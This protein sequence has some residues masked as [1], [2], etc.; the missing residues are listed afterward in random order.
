MSSL[1]TGQ[2]GHHVVKH[3]LA[4]D[5]PL[6]LVVR[7]QSKLPHVVRS[8]VE[9]IEGSHG[10]AEVVDRAFNGADALFWLAPPNPQKTLEEVYLDF[11]RP[12]AGALRKHEV[13]R[14]V[15]ITALGRGTEWQDK[16]GLVTASI[17]MED[18]LMA[19][20]VAFRGLAMPFH[21]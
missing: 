14:V 8:R 13:K 18:M 3:L 4:G 12:A 7:D 2:I 5:A 21:G 11:T 15:A 9:I 6:R 16:A 10:D 17:R 19:S 20:G 1:H